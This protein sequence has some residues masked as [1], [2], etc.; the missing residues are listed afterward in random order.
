MNYVS[1]VAAIL[2]ISPCV[3]VAA[4]EVATEIHRDDV[5]LDD[6]V[7]ISGGVA[8]VTQYRFRGV[9]LSDEKPALQAWVEV[10]HEGG[11]YAGAWASSI[12]GFGEIGGSNVELDLYAGY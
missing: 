10:T 3:P 7:T 8:G 6:H 1:A 9:E 2:V 12:D 11:V 4:Q 5:V